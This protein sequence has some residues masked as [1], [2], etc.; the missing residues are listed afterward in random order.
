RK[1][2]DFRHVDFVAHGL[3]LLRLQFSIIINLFI[4]FLDGSPGVLKGLNI[5]FQYEKYFTYLLKTI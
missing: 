2:M 1:R 4:E 5:C 3:P